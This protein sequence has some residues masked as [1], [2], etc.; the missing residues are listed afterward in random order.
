MRNTKEKFIQ[1]YACQS[2]SK[3]LAQG[4]KAFSL[5][6]LRYISKYGLNVF[7]ITT[8]LPLEMVARVLGFL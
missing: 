7:R 2:V 8:L 1:M 3:V 6:P 4:N 5:K